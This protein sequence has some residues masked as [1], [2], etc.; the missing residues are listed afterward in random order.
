MADSGL[1]LKQGLLSSSSHR[2]EGRILS[3]IYL[4]ESLT[5]YVLHKEGV[6]VFINGVEGL[7]V[8][9]GDDAK[10]L[11]H[12]SQFDVFAVVGKHRIAL[13]SKD[14]KPFFEISSKTSIIKL[15]LIYSTCTLHSY[16]PSP[17]LSLSLSLFIVVYTIHVLE[18][19][20]HQ[21]KAA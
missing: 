21:N 4:P 14:F 6:T 5:C 12:A 16:F 1:L 9:C 10:V 19:S 7:N 15:V 13:L 20:S 8:V 2:L 3:V 17:P 18:I 11:L